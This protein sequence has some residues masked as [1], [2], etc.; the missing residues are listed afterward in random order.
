MIV[1][2]LFHPEKEMFEVSLVRYIKI[3]DQGFLIYQ[4]KEAEIDQSGYGRVYVAKI[5]DHYS[6]AISED[7]W[8]ELKDQVKQIVKQNMRK[9]SLS[10]E[11]LD[12]HLLSGTIINEYRV[13]RFEQPLVEL[14]KE[15]YSLEEDDLEEE[16]IKRP[17]IKEAIR[18]PYQQKEDSNLNYKELYELMQKKNKELEEELIDLQNRTMSYQLKYDQIRKILE[19]NDEKDK[20]AS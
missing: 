10:I 12:Y 13:F 2:K 15:N 3:K 20:I 11:D 18:V 7:E 16:K 1:L 9:E 8:R 6:E 19:E 14:L 4:Q 17:Q 5:N